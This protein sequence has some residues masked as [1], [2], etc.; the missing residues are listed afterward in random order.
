MATIFTAI[1]QA[2][3]F[4]TSIGVFSLCAA[5]IL[6]REIF[7]LVCIDVFSLSQQLNWTTKIRLLLL[8]R[9]HAALRKELE[10]RET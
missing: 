2:P 8:K 4:W 1:A 10:E 5:P 9:E 3:H 6:V 7:I